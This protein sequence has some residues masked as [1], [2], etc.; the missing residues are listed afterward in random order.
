MAVPQAMSSTAELTLVCAPSMRHTPS[1][2]YLQQALG[3]RRRLGVRGRA[4]QAQRCYM[5][6][7]THVC[8]KPYPQQAL[9]RGRGLGIRGRAQQAQR[10][11]H[12]LRRGRQQRR[13]LLDPAPRRGLQASR[14]TS[15]SQLQ[16]QGLRYDLSHSDAFQTPEALPVGLDA[17]FRNQA[18]GAHV[19]Y[20][21][22]KTV[23]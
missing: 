15:M 17:C 12:A 20:D 19:Q 9:G 2:P 13:L 4:Q 14:Q 3:R 6:K 23:S 21:A 7:I 18:Q 8:M 11:P 1:T 16:L 22:A 10:V 5:T